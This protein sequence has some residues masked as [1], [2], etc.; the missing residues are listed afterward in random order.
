VAN[1]V[2]GLIYWSEYSHADTF[3]MPLTRPSIGPDIP[4]I[5]RYANPGDALA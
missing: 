1:G 4:A 5:R 3:D 2:V